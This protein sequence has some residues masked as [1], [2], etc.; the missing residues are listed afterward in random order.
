MIELSNEFGI[1][2]RTIRKDLNER[3][4]HL[5]IT[6][7]NGE[8]F[9]ETM[10]TIKNYELNN[11][12][13]KSGILGLYPKIDNQILLN[14]TNLVSGFGY[15]ILDNILFENLQKAVTKI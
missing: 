8:Y 15:E 10:P 4:S 12:A 5:Y 6:C 13:Q 2:Q 14:D 7:K 3:L 9:L 1:N 11:F